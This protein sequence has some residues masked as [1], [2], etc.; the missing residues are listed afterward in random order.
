M[1]ESVAILPAWLSMS[2]GCQMLTVSVDALHELDLNF[3]QLHHSTTILTSQVEEHALY[4]CAPRM[5]IVYHL[6]QKPTGMKE[7]GENTEWETEATSK[8]NEN[9]LMRSIATEVETISVFNINGLQELWNGW[10]HQGRLICFNKQE[11][12]RSRTKT[13]CLRFLPSKW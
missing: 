6:K 7:Y 13:S 5:L 8:H 2:K 1:L 10:Y 11:V 4:V 12:T 9:D 3:L